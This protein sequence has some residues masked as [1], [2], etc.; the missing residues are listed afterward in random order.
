MTD[1]IKSANPIYED[2]ATAP[3]VYFDGVACNGVLS[4]VIQIELANRI[5][6]PSGDGGVLLKFI[7]SGRLRCS[8]H[9]C[10]QLIG[11]L[12][13]ALQMLD[14]PQEPAPTAGQLN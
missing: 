13:Q 14:K 7:T 8:A 3:V 11:A 10:R 5:L 4:G 1:E 9:A 6:V 12:E 2:V